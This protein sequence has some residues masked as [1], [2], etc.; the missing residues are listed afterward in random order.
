M[1]RWILPAATLLLVALSL[2]FV[3][4]AAGLGWSGMWA[5]LSDTSRIFHADAPLANTAIAAHMILGA[6]LTLAAPVQALPVVR[7]RLPGVHRRAGYVIALAA[8]LTGAGGL[9][10][11]AA[12]GTVGGWWMSLWFAIYGVAMIVAATQVIYHALDKNMARHRA[13]A[14]RLVVLA[15][16][17][18]LYRVHYGLWYAA[19]G[20]AA[21]N[22]AFT[23][24]FDRINVVAFFVPYLL[25]AEL[26]LRR[27]GPRRN[28][29]R[30][31]TVRKA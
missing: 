23:G 3:L 31:A 10:Y 18:F 26:Y 6:A 21:S 4:H 5:D 13:W 2:P 9:A 8:V 27:R 22:E 12:R 29:A 15:V 30:R 11:I 28:P 20:G 7:N 17:S 1:T 16:A 25:L 24:A 14:V 19:T